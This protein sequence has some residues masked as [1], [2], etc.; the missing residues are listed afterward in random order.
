[1]SCTRRS[2][3][4][5]SN[6][7]ALRGAE[8]PGFSDVAEAD[9]IYRTQ[10][11]VEDRRED[12]ERLGADE[13]GADRSHVLLQRTR[14][15]RRVSQDAD[16]LRG[17]DR[18]EPAEKANKVLLIRTLIREPVWKPP[19]GL[20]PLA[21]EST[22]TSICVTRDMRFSRANERESGRQVM[23]TVILSMYCRKAT[24]SSAH[25]QWRCSHR[26]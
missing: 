25:C 23:Y 19:D 26:E 2:S 5:I 24:P 3:P 21:T 9:D 7:G 16:A 15:R 17:G 18:K 4:A 13:H 8:V 14:D 1:M 12:C 20:R 6:E 11:E 22:S 10:V